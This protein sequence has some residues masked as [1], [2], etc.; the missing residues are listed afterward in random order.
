MPIGNGFGAG[1]PIPTGG[2]SGH[3]A[4]LGRA[5]SFKIAVSKRPVPFFW[6]SQSRVDVQ[7]ITSTL[8]A[9]C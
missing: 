4:K 5:L 8:E 6:S 1:G 2:F 9:H 7:G 3:T